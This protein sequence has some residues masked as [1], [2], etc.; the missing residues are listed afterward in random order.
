VEDIAYLGNLSTYRV[1]LD[2]GKI[3]RLTRTNR[4]RSDEDKITW[5]DKVY[6]T[7]DDKAGVVLTS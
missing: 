1:R 4:A 2:S 6:I 7:W 3:M 5:E